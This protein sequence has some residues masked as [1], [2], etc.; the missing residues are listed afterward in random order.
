MTKRER[1]EIDIARELRAAEAAEDQGDYYYAEEC[2]RSA[3][4][5][6]KELDVVIFAEYVIAELVG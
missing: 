3:R 4:Y 1:L 2:M 5:L 6:L